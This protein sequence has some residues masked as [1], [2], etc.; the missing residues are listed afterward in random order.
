VAGEGLSDGFYIWTNPVTGLTYALNT[1]LV[2]A[3]HTLPPYLIVL[4]QIKE[5][6]A[7]FYNAIINSLAAMAD[8]DDRRV[9]ALE[10]L[11]SF[12]T[13]LLKLKATTGVA[14]SIE[15]IIA[16]TEKKI[17]D[18]TDAMTV[19]RSFIA[20]R[21]Y[22][23]YV[24]GVKELANEEGEVV[25]NIDQ[26]NE[27]RKV[28]NP[29]SREQINN[30]KEAIRQV[31]T[32]YDGLLAFGP[33]NLPTLNLTSKSS[34]NES[35]NEASAV[36]HAR[37]TARFNDVDGVTWPNAIAAL[38]AAVNG[39][40]VFLPDTVTGVSPDSER[41]EFALE[42]KF[43][44]SFFRAPITSSLALLQSLH[45]DGIV[46]P[47]VK[48][49][50]PENGFTT[51]LE[52]DD[53]NEGVLAEK[54][55]RRSAYLTIGDIASNAYNKEN[56][57]YM[58]GHKVSEPSRPQQQNTK[59]IGASAFF[60]GADAGLGKRKTIGDFGGGQDERMEKERVNLDGIKRRRN[61]GAYYNAST[62][63]EPHGPLVTKVLM[64]NFKKV[65]SKPL[66]I[67]MVVH[68]ILMLPCNK[69]SVISAMIDNGIYV[70]FNVINWRPFI[71][72]DMASMI[73]MKKGLD[74]GANY[75]NKCNLMMQSD[76][77]V[78][79]MIA[80]FTF[81]AKS[82][83]QNGKN[84][85]QIEDVIPYAFRGGCNLEYI[86][87]WRDIQEDGVGRK[88]IIATL[89][90]ATEVNLGT[91]IALEGFLPISEANPAHDV[92]DIAGYWNYGFYEGKYHF[93]RLSRLGLQHQ[94]FA[95]VGDRINSTCLKG[96]KMGF[97]HVSGKYDA[98]R[99]SMGHRG[100]DGNGRGCAAI[101]KGS[102]RQF[103]CFNQAEYTLL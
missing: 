45:R 81:H 96:A 17:T 92:I 72:H 11:N 51:P 1:R 87:S 78:K 88:S 58:E 3:T 69:W 4:T 34:A 59:R 32:L 26:I 54:F 37:D 38:R 97:N 65:E 76:A 22:K 16:A 49:G 89:S 18:G 30:A 28:V 19:L 56:L 70:P 67:R 95:E 33:T 75:F 13:K 100:P 8:T 6:T 57:K 60:K 103:P 31:F 98:W 84:V 14:A 47:L 90:P 10:L 74:T 7:G 39:I 91:S 55:Y 29:L 71:T 35:L 25:L 40:S 41:T 48:P 73:L 15:H 86:D 93:G 79:T 83:V 66:L 52:A 43:S 82:V 94:T 20:T 44:A 64:S 61:D 50:N 68:A 101:Y 5:G 77:A 12:A 36:A 9:E 80:T 24:S 23:E 2:S 85:Y 99:P 63:G 62:A 21:K 102:Q 53:T 27:N 42:D 46:A